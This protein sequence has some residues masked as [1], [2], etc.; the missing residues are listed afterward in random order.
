MGT[1]SILYL[2]SRLLYGIM[3]GKFSLYISVY[4]Y[5]YTLNLKKR[6]AEECGGGEEEVHLKLH[7]VQQIALHLTPDNFC[8]FAE[9]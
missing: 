8:Q 5:I 3:K 1:R 9:L 4:H 2:I 6:G 7:R